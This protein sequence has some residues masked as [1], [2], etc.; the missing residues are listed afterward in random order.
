VG[1]DALM[2]KQ[3]RPALPD[4]VYRGD[5]ACTGREAVEEEERR[6]HHGQEITEFSTI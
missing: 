2:A 6:F 4:P 5:R 3:V 1:Y